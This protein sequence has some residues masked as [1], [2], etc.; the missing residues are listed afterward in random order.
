MIPQHDIDHAVGAERYTVRC[1]LIHFAFKSNERLDIFQHAVVVGI[2]QA[3]Q[4]RAVRSVRRD[5]DVA[6]QR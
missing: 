4:A 2:R 3:I 5:K 1:M 6:V